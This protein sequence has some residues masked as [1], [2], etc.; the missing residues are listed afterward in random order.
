MDLLSSNLIRPLNAAENHF[1]EVLVSEFSL[2]RK[3][4]GS[5]LRI[6][7]DKNTPAI[8]TREAKNEVQRM[9]PDFK[10][11]ASEYQEK[12]DAFLLRSEDQV[13]PFNDPGFPFRYASG[14]TLPVIRIGEKEYYCLFY[15]DIFPVGWNIANG[16]CDD[17]NELLYPLDAMERELREE[18]VI[19]NI[20]GGK[21][22]VFEVDAGKSLD[23]PQFA[24]LRRF[25]KKRFGW[26]DLAKYNEVIPP[27]KWLDGPDCLSVK[28]GEDDPSIVTGCFLNINAEDFGIEIDKIAKIY[29][30]EEAILIDG[31]IINGTLVNA[32]VG[33]F[34]VDRLNRE[35]TENRAEYYPDLFYY[36]ISRHG[37]F[38][39]TLKGGHELIDVINK[40]FI[41]EIDKQRSPNEIAYY[42]SCKDKFN[43]C[44]VT[45]RILKRYIALP[46]GP[47]I[48]PGNYEIFISWGGDDV[49]YAQKVYEFFKP[50][51]KTFFSRVTIGNPNFQ[52]AIDNALDSAKYLITVATKPDNLKRN[53][54][55]FESSAFHIGILNRR[56]SPGSRII[57]FITGFKPEYLPLP[58]AVYQAVEFDLNDMQTGLNRLADF[59]CQ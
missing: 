53:W 4:P 15:R 26:L 14:G 9:I 28:I 22:Y 35:V 18:L 25:F 6:Q 16:G 21:R 5:E 24:V 52:I 12:L 1:L 38:N 57:P 31:E 32:V 13:Y 27:L 44:P 30:D 45:N 47:N 34:E 8:W 41:P 43:L 17:R 20:N 37:D 54:V 2:Q 36:D 50:R 39:N 29:L 56:K 19:L 3:G 51:R 59:I 46:E 33:L 11:K 40:K 10:K 49:N 23:H 55:E 58:L 7:F 48:E 42:A